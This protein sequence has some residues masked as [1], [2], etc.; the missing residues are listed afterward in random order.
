MVKTLKQKK[1]TKQFTRKNI[2]V[3]YKN[4]SGYNKNN[5][6]VDK[7]VITTYGEMTID[8]IEKLTTLLNSL[9]NV[10]DYPEDRQVFYDLGSGIGKIVITIASLVPN[11]KSVGVEIIK[12]RHSQAL[13]ALQKIKN[14]P[15]K[16][17]I[18]FILDSL[19]NTDLSNACWIYVS[20][21]CFTNEMNDKLSQKLINETQLNTLIVCSMQFNLPE[22]LFKLTG[23]YNIPM[24][25]SNASNVY[26][27][28]RI[29]A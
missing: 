15:V 18:S 12:S 22:N 21:L 19:Y 7:D 6:E 14:V 25:W 2:E 26:I 10:S 5:Q 9:H 1:K 13:L 24:S 4:L 16:N 27:Y 11:I 20:N 28:K 29:L 3:I 17:R 23:K 8:G